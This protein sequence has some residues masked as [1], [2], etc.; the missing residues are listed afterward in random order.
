MDMYPDL[1]G[2]DKKDI[3]AIVIKQE[4]DV[5]VKQKATYSDNKMRMYAIAYGQC[6]EGMRAKL[7]SETGFAE[8]A[9]ESD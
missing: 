9:A 7:E 4:Y 2:V 5:Y 1:Q 8:V 6:S 3:A